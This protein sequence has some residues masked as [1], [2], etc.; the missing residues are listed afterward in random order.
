VSRLCSPGASLSSALR[1]ARLDR[2]ALGRGAAL[3][4]RPG[5]A[6]TRCAR[7]R[8]RGASASKAELKLRGLGEQSLLT[9]EI[10]TSISSI[11]FVERD[12]ALSHAPF[13]SP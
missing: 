13:V 8:D 12:A 3:T 9:L 2:P 5:A 6:D 4:G 10:A 7:G 11:R 1:R